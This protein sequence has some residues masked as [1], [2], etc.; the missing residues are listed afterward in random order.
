MVPVA[1]QLLERCP[2]PE[3]RPCFSRLWKPESAH[4]EGGDV[5]QGPRIHPNHLG[6]TPVHAADL[7]GFDQ[8]NDSSKTSLGRPDSLLEHSMGLASGNRGSYG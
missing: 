5:L 3:Y 1:L 2:D 6:R 4:G 7:G 8:E